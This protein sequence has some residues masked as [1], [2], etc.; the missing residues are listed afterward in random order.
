[1]RSVTPQF[2]TKIASTAEDIQAGQ[3]LRYRVF[4]QELGA[5]GDMV[6]HTLRREVDRF[7]AHADHLLLF[8]RARHADDQVV[9]VYRLMDRAAAQAAGQFYTETEYDLSPLLQTERP[10][11]ELGRSCIHPEYRSGAAL[12]VL[13]QALAQEVTQ[14]GAE[15][16]FG[17]ASFHGTDLASLGPALSLLARDHSAPANLRPRARSYQSMHITE[18]IDRLGAMKT[19]PSLIKAYL[20]LGGGVGDG[21]FLDHSFNTTDVCLILDTHQMSDRQRAI[22]GGRP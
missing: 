4:V 7:D 11:L 3:S 8:D 1:M 15:I 21:A 20:R 17:T 18:T 9:G 12:M 19:I 16:L 5:T 6:D 2:E 13:W 22:Y 10:L 14:R